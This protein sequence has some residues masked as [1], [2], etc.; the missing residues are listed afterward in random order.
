MAKNGVRPNI[1]KAVT[2]NCGHVE[3]KRTPPR[4]PRCSFIMHLLFVFV[5]LIDKTN[6]TEQTQANIFA[7]NSRDV[8]RLVPSVQQCYWTDS[9]AGCV[10]YH[11]HVCL[12]VPLRF[13]EVKRFLWFNEGS[14]H[15]R[16]FRMLSKWGGRRD[17]QL[18]LYTNSPPK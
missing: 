7:S 17:N 14:H 1:T 8:A 5:S 13:N 16:F 9:V 4:A 10:S 18:H 6:L 3:F 11:I 2:Q 12:S 15:Q